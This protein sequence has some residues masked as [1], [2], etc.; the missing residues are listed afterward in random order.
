M[1]GFDID[2]LLRFTPP[3]FMCER[4]CGLIV[5]VQP[6]AS[7]W[8]CPVCDED[9][10]STDEYPT[11]LEAMRARGMQLAFHDLVAHSQKLARVARNTRASMMKRNPS[12]PPLRALFETLASAEK[13][14]HFSTY[15]ISAML[16]GALK[17]ASLRVDVRGVVS[18]VK[19]DALYKE[20]TGYT[21]ETPRLNLRVYNGESAYFPH[22]KI[23]VVDGL[24]AFKGSANLT[25]FGWRRAAYGREVIE[26]VTDIDE[27]IGLNNRFFSPVWLAE[28]ALDAPEGMD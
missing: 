16:L 10:L 14:I 6:N 27:V 2:S 9:Y 26:A 24:M 1:Q 8:R 11:A 19:N 12:Y 17:M 3:E 18:G 4:C 23:V 5:N 20:L 25:D 7:R 28:P 15:G 13:F 21:N 22:Q